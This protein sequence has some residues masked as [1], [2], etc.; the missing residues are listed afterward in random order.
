M[1]ILIKENVVRGTMNM[2]EVL[3]SCFILPVQNFIGSP[4]HIVLCYTFHVV[5]KQFFFPFGYGAEIPVHKRIVPL[6]KAGGHQFLKLKK[7]KKTEMR[8][9]FMS[10]C[11]G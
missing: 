7:F 10:C 11:D 9:K 5:M 3:R 1:G 2:Q 6:V 4:F 8:R